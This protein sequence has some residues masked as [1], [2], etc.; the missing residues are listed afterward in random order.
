M[1]FST[2]ITD[3]AVK[4]RLSRDVVVRKLAL[5]AFAGILKRS[6]VRTGRFRS[7]NRLSIGRADTSVAPDFGDPVD[8]AKSYPGG[9]EFEVARGEVMQLKFGTTVHI[10]NNLPYAVPLE[11]GSSKQTNSMPGGIYQATF[12]ELVAKLSQTIRSARIG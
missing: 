2:D 11:D 10:T 6:P 5:D 9:L 4:T 7:S 12:D 3:W 1:S 8:K